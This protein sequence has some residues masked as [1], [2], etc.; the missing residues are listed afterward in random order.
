MRKLLPILGF[1]YPLGIYLLE[2]NIK[3]QTNTH[4]IIAK[5][6]LL[7]PVLYSIGGLALFAQSLQHEPTF[8]AR[9]ARRFHPDLSE[10]E[11]AHCRQA[12]QAWCVFFIANILITTLLALCAPLLWWAIYANLISYVM[13]GL[14][15]GFEHLIRWHKFPE[16]KPTW[17]PQCTRR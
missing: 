14:M 3:I 8:V 15:I 17:L 7:V 9:I 4:Y 12:T 11:I 5:L 1:L 6:A 13:I 16:R 2:R 10:K